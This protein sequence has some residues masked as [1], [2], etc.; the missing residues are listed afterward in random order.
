MIIVG[1]M[2]THFDSSKMSKTKKLLKV[3]DVAVMHEIQNVLSMIEKFTIPTVLF[4]I[5]PQSH[6]LQC[7]HLQIK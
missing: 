2:H 6:Q 1:D 4:S 5:Q 7:K 3:Q